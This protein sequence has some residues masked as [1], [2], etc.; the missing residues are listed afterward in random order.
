MFTNFSKIIERALKKCEPMKTVFIRKQSDTTIQQKWVTE[1]TRKLYKK[2]NPR[3]NPK[4]MKYQKLQNDFSKKLVLLFWLARFYLP[5]IFQKTRISGT[6]EA[7]NTRRT[8]NLINCLKNR[9]EK[10]ALT[11]IE[12]R[13]WIFDSQIYVIISAYLSL[14]LINDL[15]KYR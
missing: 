4:D 6:S 14:I 5:I 12:L 3:M 10:V 1:E 8:K 7:R 11:K 9:S 15:M 2:I 13:I